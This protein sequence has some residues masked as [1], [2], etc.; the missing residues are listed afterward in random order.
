MSPT[1][2][3]PATNPTA[4]MEQGR[5]LSHNQQPVSANG[6]NKNNNY[7]KRLRLEDVTPPTDVDISGF[8]YDPNN[9]NRYAMFA[10]LEFENIQQ[11]PQTNNIDPKQSPQKEKTSFCPPIFLYNINVLR[12][13]KQLEDKSPPINFKIKN[14][15]T[16]KCKLYLSDPTA[17]TAMLETL[18]EKSVHAYSFTPKE[19]KQV[20]FILRGLCHG[21]EAE[22]VKNA[23]D[24]V[25][26]EVIS[27][28]SKF[29]TSRS[30][31]NNL[32]T[33]LFLVTLNPG[34]SL[35]DISHI[36]YL[37]KQSLTWSNTMSQVPKTAALNIIA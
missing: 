33:G 28:V 36:K 24:E 7:G 21:V 10:D 6:L 19:L 16:N 12:L 1:L 8:K 3:I 18:R 35:S 23:L 13:I 31:K 15:G 27:K 34:K 22:Y 29:K 14:V 30:I 5:P 32:D 9:Q 4:P 37:H 11:A 26:P 2:M 20:S 17:H 25:L